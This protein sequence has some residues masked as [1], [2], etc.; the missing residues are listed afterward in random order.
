MTSFLTE[1]KDG[2]MNLNLEIGRVYKLDHQRKGVFIAQLTGIEEGDEADEQFLTMKYD[3]RIGTDQARLAISPKDEVRV[4]NIR[5][6][7]IIAIEETEDG[8]W[9][10][11]KKNPKRK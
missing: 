5:P 11:Q 3:V 6:S 2:T 4:S 8:E 10:L 7:L 9:R 1:N